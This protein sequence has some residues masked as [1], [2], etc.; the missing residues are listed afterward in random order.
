MKYLLIAL[1]LTSCANTDVY[2]PK[3]NRL[4]H[5]QADADLLDFKS[6]ETSLH[7]VGLRHSTA[8]QAG[9][10]ASTSVVTSAGTA[11]GNII[12]AIIAKP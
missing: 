5:T 4:F 12:R 10:A 2:G 11:T 3:G 1:L 6:G 7:I 8:T 9:G